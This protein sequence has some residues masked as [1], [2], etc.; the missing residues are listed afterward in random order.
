MGNAI[1]AIPGFVGLYLMLR[2]AGTEQ[3]ALVLV[4]AVIFYAL[5][6]ATL[7]RD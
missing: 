5:V 2:S 4:G 3:A 7:L 6:S 1:F